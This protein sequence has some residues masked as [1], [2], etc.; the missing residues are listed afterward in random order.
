MGICRQAAAVITELDEQ[1]I[2]VSVGTEGRLVPIVHMVLTEEHLAQEEADFYG[3]AT[4]QGA[5]R[6]H[7]P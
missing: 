6:P 7:H 1:S 5:D 3:A 2:T 4:A